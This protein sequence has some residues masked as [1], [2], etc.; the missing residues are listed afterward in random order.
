LSRALFLTKEYLAD[1]FWATS[2]TEHVYD[3]ALHGFGRLQYD[4]SRFQSSQDLTPYRWI[5]D[6]SKQTTDGP[7]SVEWVQQSAGVV[8]GS[9]TSRHTDAWFTTQA[10]AKMWMLGAPGT[11]AY[12]GEG[13]L[14][15]SDLERGM[16]QRPEDP[17]GRLPMVVARRQAAGALYAALHEPV[18]LR[19]NGKPV[20]QHRIR[21]FEPVAQNAD[22][23]AVKIVGPDYIDY[24]MVG[25]GNPLDE[26]REVTL[27]NPTSGEH[28][29]FRSF[30]YLRCQAKSVVGR[31]NLAGCVIAGGKEGPPALTLNGEPAPINASDGRWSFGN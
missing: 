9:P 30:A 27:T 11:A 17:E 6:A 15:I 18:L 12:V 21:G 13:P 20:D 16:S 1:F 7:W 24:V 26:K 25:F 22:A 5:K 23:I 19:D 14:L 2:Q 29:T 3:W 8:K 28:F 31:G 4:R 10:G